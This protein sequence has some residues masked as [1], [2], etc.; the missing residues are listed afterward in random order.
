MG[1]H[2]IKVK[3]A[4]QGKLVPTCCA[5]LFLF[6]SSFSLLHWGGGGR[7]EERRIEIQY[8]AA[9]ATILKILTNLASQYYNLQ[10]YCTVSIKQHCYHQKKLENKICNQN[11][12][13]VSKKFL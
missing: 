11:S 12:I 7:E 4:T 1:F 2:P 9:S 3:G 10:T 6:M 5:E 8:I 13:Y